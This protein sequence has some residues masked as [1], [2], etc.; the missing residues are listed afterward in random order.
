[1]AQEA[2]IRQ[3]RPDLPLKINLSIG[4]RRRT[5]SSYGEENGK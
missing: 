4:G 1:M 2:F 3:D 5:N